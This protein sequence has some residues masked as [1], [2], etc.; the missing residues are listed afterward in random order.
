MPTVCLGGST[1]AHKLAAFV[2][3]CHLENYTLKGT[4]AHVEDCFKVCLWGEDLG[5]SKG[6]GAVLMGISSRG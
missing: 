6:V 5:K 4:V 2:H 3:S 1:T